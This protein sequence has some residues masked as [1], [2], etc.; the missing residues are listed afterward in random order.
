ML[1]GKPVI[2]NVDEYI[3][4]FPVEIQIILKEIRKTIKEAAP[5]SIEKISYGM[6]TYY[7]KTNLIHFAAYKK[8]IG[9][10]PTP[11]G[12]KAFNE[13]LKEYKWSKG[14]IQLPLTKPIPYD[15]IRRLVLFRISEI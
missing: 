8:H 3:K 13:E 4:T 12:V 7:Q 6:P 9:I 15:L 10:Y 1:E 14:S 11:S 2:G 5:L